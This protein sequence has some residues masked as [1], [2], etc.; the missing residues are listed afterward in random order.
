MSASHHHQQSLKY[1]GGVRNIDTI[2]SLACKTR[3]EIISILKK[4]PT[5]I[6]DELWSNRSIIPIDRNCIY[7][8]NQSCYSDINPL[9]RK[10]YRC[11]GCMIMSRLV[12]TDNYETNKPFTVEYGRYANKQMIL[13]KIPIDI[14]ELKL[15][16]TINNNL[17][18]LGTDK[19]TNQLLVTWYVDSILSRVNLFFINRIHLAFI[20]DNNGYLLK[21]T[22]TIGSIKDLST[23]IFHTRIIV[24]PSVE[25]TS[26]LRMFEQSITILTSSTIVDI[27]KQLITSLRILQSYNFS[28]GGVNSSSLVFTSGHVTYQYDGINIATD[29]MI[30]FDN[31]NNGSIT[32]SDNNIPQ[33]H[34]STHK[35]RLYRYSPLDKVQT[36]NISSQTQFITSE[37]SN[38][39]SLCQSSQPLSKPY[40]VYR[41]S[42]KNK[43]ISQSL[44][45]MPGSYCQI[46]HDN[47]SNYQSSYDIYSFIILLMSNFAFYGGVSEDEKLFHMWKS[48]WTPCDFNNINV[49]IR[50]FHKYDVITSKDIEK[51]L[52]KYFLRFDASDLLWEFMKLYFP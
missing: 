16:Q 28:Y 2:L 50:K 42:N 49:D 33:T 20:C 17:Y 10:L 13:I 44:S 51:I 11:S 19:F 5:K 32:I 21:E 1:C 15:D 26:Y 35:V 8:L 34:Q 9:V 40:T 46:H 38:K 41:I 36:D 6:I 52:S 22:S 14:L 27:L 4:N 18:F 3:N 30:K 43:N 47:A 37:F 23:N 7:Q 24:K 48:I 12:D 29:F 25:S 45:Q 39:E 31:I